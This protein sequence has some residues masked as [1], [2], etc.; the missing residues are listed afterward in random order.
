MLEFPPA[1]AAAVR[2]LDEHWNGKGQPDGL[3]GEAIPIL[4][5]IACVAQTVEVFHHDRG[6]D[7]VREMLRER[8]GRWFDPELADALLGLPDGDDLWLGGSRE[9]GR[10]GCATSAPDDVVLVADE[11]RLD[12][13]A[14]AFAQVIDAK[15]PFTFNHSS[16]VADY[17][18]R[19]ATELGHGPAPSAPCAAWACCTTSASSA[20]RAASSTSRRS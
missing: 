14:E 18:M 17:A 9:D 16:G 10:A 4:A 3:K 1:A 5:R 6:V 12:R 15:S 11:E 8:R 20:S 7:G 19:I 2:S 13:M